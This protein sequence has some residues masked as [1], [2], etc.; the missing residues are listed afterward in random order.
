M[1]Q[2]RCQP[3]T[4]TETD[5]QTRT[6]ATA[7]QKIIV[8]ATLETNTTQSMRVAARISVAGAPPDRLCQMRRRGGANRENS[9]CR[10]TP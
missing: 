9:P 7:G 5:D 8:H 3:F 10:R 1:A 2:R 6:K 4:W